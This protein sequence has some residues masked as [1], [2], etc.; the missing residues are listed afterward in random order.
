[1]R[2]AFTIKNGSEK[3]WNH[4]GKKKREDTCDE[5]MNWLLYS[6]VLVYIKL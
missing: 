5:A 1:M 4:A 3:G 6:V 2:N